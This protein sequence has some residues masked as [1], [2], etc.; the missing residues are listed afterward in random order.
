MWGGTYVGEFS[1]AKNPSTDKNVLDK[2][3][4]DIYKIEVNADL[5]Y[6]T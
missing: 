6:Y 5:L 1:T 3:T 2:V 4:I